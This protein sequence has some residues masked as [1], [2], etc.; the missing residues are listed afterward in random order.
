MGIN[1][2]ALAQIRGGFFSKIPYTNHND[3]QTTT[4]QYITN[5][6]LW[7]SLVVKTLIA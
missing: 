3:I 7:V 6:I 1:D 5:D 2:N 4:M